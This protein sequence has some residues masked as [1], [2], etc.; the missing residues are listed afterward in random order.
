MGR[1]ERARRDRKRNLG[2]ADVVTWLEGD[3]LHALV[4]ADASHA[5]VEEMTKRYQENIRRSPLWDLMVKEYGEEQ[6][7]RLLEQFRV[8]RK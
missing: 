4:P 6:A 1:R 7:A 3:G 5:T 2:R 8:E